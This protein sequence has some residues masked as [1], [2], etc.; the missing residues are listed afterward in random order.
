[1]V[2][3]KYDSIFVI[4]YTNDLLKYSLVLI[5]LEVQTIHENVITFIF[6][7]L[8]LLIR[9]HLHHLF[10]KL[11][12]LSTHQPPLSTNFNL[13]MH[14]KI[15]IYSSYLISYPHKSFLFYFLSRFISKI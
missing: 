14:L 2:F 10:T 3:F 13:K 9:H 6:S 11:P 1:M 15:D 4:K 8:F 5:T 12:L 7:K